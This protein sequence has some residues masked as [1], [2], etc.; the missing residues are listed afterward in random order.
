MEIVNELLKKETIDTVILLGAIIIGI[1][2]ILGM[3]TL[4]LKV[5]RVEKI[6]VGGIECDPEE[7]KSQVKRTAKKKAVK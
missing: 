5:A 1:I 6:G 3:L 2:L 7:E 4:F